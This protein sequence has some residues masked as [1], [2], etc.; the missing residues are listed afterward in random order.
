M[1]G[2]TSPTPP[3]RLLGR[4]PSN[5]LQCSLNCKTQDAKLLTTEV[6][7]QVTGDTLALGLWEGLWEEL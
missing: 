2:K 1:G 4:H 7:A 3:F 6:E 5:I